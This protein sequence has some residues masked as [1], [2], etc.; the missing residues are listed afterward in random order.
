[1][2]ITAK[3]CQSSHLQFDHSNEF[4][5]N[6][7]EEFLEH[8]A[9]GAL[10]I[11][12]WGHRSAGFSSM[13]TEWEITDAQTKISRSLAD[14]WAELKR[15]I[16]LWVE[17]H[18]LNEQGEY[19][20]VEVTPKPD[21]VTGGV[22]QLRQGQQRR[23]LVRVN[24]VQ[25][26]GTLPVIC[27]AVTSL[28]I[29]CV[30][31]RSK[32]QKSLDSYQEEDLT[33]LNDKWSEALL[34]LKTY[35][36]E[37]IQLLLHKPDKTEEDI[38]REQHLIEQW[39]SLTEERNAFKCPAP[40]S[41]IPGAPADWDP[42]SGMECHIPVLFLD[43]N[44][45]DMTNM[46]SVGDSLMVAGANS[47]LPKEHGGQFFNLP[48]VKFCEKNV[49]AVA[50]WDSSMH[51]SPALNR[52]TTANE[53]V[54]MILKASVRLSHP[55]VMEIVLRKRLA[56][57]VYKKQSI[58]QMFK[59]K[60]VRCDYLTATGVTYEV[61]S[62]IP[63]SSE[64]I[65]DRESLALMAASC[66]NSTIFDGESYIE[67]Y[68][69]G[70][71]AVES[72]LTLDRLRQEVA[73]KELL[74]LKNN[75]QAFIRKTASVPNIGVLFGSTLGGSLS[76]LDHRSDSAFD[77]SFLTNSAYEGFDRFRQKANSL[78]AGSNSSTP[79]SELHSR[80]SLP[81]TPSETS[82][83]SRSFGPTR[84]NFLNLNLNLN[85]A[86]R[87]A[88]NGKSITII[89]KIFSFFRE[90]SPL[91][92]MSPHSTKF[93]KP[94][95]TVKP[96]SSNISTNN[97]P[98][99]RASTT[100]QPESKLNNAGTPSM[101][102]GYGSQP[103]LETPVSSEESIS[104]HSNSEEMTIISDVSVMKK[105]ASVT[106]NNAEEIN[107][108]F[109]GNASPMSVRNDNKN[110]VYSD[111]DNDSLSSYGS[112]GDYVSVGDNSGGRSLP[113]W[114]TVGENVRVSPDF[115]TGV[116]AFIGTTHFSTGIWVG[117][118]LD[119]PLGKNNGSVDGVQYFTCKPRF[120]LFVRPDKLKLDSRAR[121]LRMSKSHDT[122]L[123][124]GSHTSVHSEHFSAF[125][126][127]ALLNFTFL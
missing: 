50:V 86:L 49:C 35:L 93:V 66:D 111:N 64:D 33:S 27:E 53:R 52:V 101:S 29:G 105:S 48:I 51:D 25:D 73:I 117:I 19:S 108:Q 43:L 83:Q 63:K 122:F 121:A 68:T 38:E 96:E 85:I 14:R 17:I 20:P 54:Y 11:E 126:S 9:E 5:V 15:K 46:S 103:L 45:D 32:L 91:N 69:K 59:R 88:T 76:R 10:S 118:I 2:L 106:T 125:S 55:S 42:P 36:D 94:M 114:L 99:N 44:P 3:R 78:L 100:V 74:T 16:E 12:V 34:K 109:N 113:E 60:L 37:Q 31:V 26:S 102:S 124:T 87:Q 40:G 116:V 115:K 97:I 110:L 58:S 7:T 62:N 23:I 123:R 18:E 1:S 71:S 92:S 30:S 112:R 6:V 61:V 21:N 57:N 107:N 84:P 104:L 8:C 39:V 80:S 81:N 120:G 24:P 65:E 22:Y 127:E 90:A 82:M 95:K 4:A 56:I 67:K 79:H 13:R 98:D 75:Q 77:I 119:A 70:V 89:N 47:I 28:A 41:E 72:I